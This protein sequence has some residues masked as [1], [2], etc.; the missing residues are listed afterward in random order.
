MTK[1]YLIPNAELPDDHWAFGIRVYL[2][3]II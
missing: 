1:E 3:I 2:V